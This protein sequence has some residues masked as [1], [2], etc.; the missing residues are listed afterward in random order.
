MK[1]IGIDPDMGGG[2]ALV[3][4]PDRKVLRL[5]RM[6]LTEK[7]PPLNARRRVHPEALW[8]VLVDMRSSGAEYVILE[9][10]VVKPQIGK[11][12]KQVMQGGIDRTH[13]NFGAIRALCELAFT[14]SRVMLATPSV[15]KKALG[16]TSDK[17]L[18]RSMACQLY[19]GHEQL[20]RMTK[21]TGIAE[22]LLL[23]EWGLGEFKFT[24]G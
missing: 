18:S 2:L 13:Q 6:P 1:L 21:N 22:A 10:P 5:E 12:G 3:D 15:W 14:G 8:K 9:A 4:L 24:G 16:L 23:A 20:L 11:G 19:P 7:K 17:E